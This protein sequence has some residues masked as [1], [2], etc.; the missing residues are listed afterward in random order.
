MAWARNIGV[1]TTNQRIA[2]IVGAWVSVIAVKFIDVQIRVWN[3]TFTLGVAGFPNCA[4]VSVVACSKVGPG[5]ASSGRIAPVDFAHMT[6]ITVSRLTHT[7]A[8]NAA[9][10]HVASV[11]PPSGIAGSAINRRKDTAGIRITRIN[12]ARITIIT[13]T[14]DSCTNERIAVAVVVDGT[15]ISIVTWVGIVILVNTPTLRTIYA[16]VLGT[17]ISI[18]A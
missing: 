7:L 5:L 16:G 1:Y 2:P 8:L 17:W 3:L 14:W 4:C 9:V 6:T 12:G 10:V 13:N 18:V 11:C 15:C